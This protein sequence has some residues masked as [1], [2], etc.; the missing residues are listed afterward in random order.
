MSTVERAEAIA[1]EAHEGAVDKGGH[2]YVLHVLRV[3]AAV[4][5]QA[6]IAALL[7]DV[8]EDCDEWTLD[9]LRREGFAHEI[10]VAVDHLTRR[11]GESYSEF[12]ARC[13]ENLM[14]RIV[15]RADLLDNMDLSRL[16][17]I[18]KSDEARRRKYERALAELEE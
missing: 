15:K 12:I 11:Y 9:R 17:T 13:K 7:H 10:V 18:T 5:G 2:P 3:A 4:T 6:K 1:R 14:A 16:A 8:V